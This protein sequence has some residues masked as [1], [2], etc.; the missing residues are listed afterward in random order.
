MTFTYLKGYSEIFKKIT[1]KHGVKTALR[2]GTKVKEIKSKARTPLGE[3]KANVV[4]SIPYKCKNDIYIEETY[5]IFETRKKEHEAK[6]RLPKKDLKEGN[7]ESAETRMGKED[8]GIDRHSTQCSQR[9]DSK[10]S[11]VVVTVK[12]T[13][14]RIV[15]EGV[16]S[17]KLKFRGKTPSIITITRRMEIGDNRTCK[18]TAPYKRLKRKY[19]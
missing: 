18:V 12:N 16:E 10:K 6:V 7:I 1:S 11:K 14:Q 3:K 5:R 17:E 19:F 13:K 4:Y 9:I 2:P 15:R 8:G